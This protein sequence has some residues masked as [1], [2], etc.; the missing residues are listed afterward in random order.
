MSKNEELLK[1]MSEL[2]EGFIEEAEK[3]K[4]HTKGMLWKQLG[5]IAACALIAVSLAATP[6]ISKLSDNHEL[7]TELVDV[8]Y[9]RGQYVWDKTTGAF[10]WKMET[11]QDTEGKNEADE[12][13]AVIETGIVP[14]VG[15]PGG[16]SSALQTTTKPLEYEQAALMY[17]FIRGE[18]R[19]HALSFGYVMKS[20]IE[21]SLGAVT[22]TD[23]KG[24]K[25]TTH[26]KAAELFRI[27]GIDPA[28]AVAVK[29]EGFERYHVFINSSAQSETLTALK[30]AYSL[31]SKLYMGEV[32]V[33][34][35]M[36]TNTNTYKEFS[37]MTTL[38][39]MI[40]A[41]EGEAYS[42]Q[43][44]IKNRP[45]NVN[46]MGIGVTHISLNGMGQ[47]AIQIYEDGYLQTNIGGVLQ[48]FQIDT[49]A[50][51]EIIAYAREKNLDGVAFYDGSNTETE[52]G[53]MEVVTS[54]ALPVYYRLAGEYPL[55]LG[56][57]ASYQ[58][59]YG[60]VFEQHIE[61]CLGEVTMS[62]SK[63]SDTKQ[64]EIFRIHGIDPN[65]A[66]ALKFKDKTGNRDGEYLDQYE[67]YVNTEAEYAS[68]DALKEAYSLEEWLYLGNIHS[69]VN[70]TCI[71]RENVIAL[72]KMILSLNGA[73]CEE[74]EFEEGCMKQEWIKIRSYH[75]SFIGMTGNFVEIYT[76]GYLCVRIGKQD[77]FFKIDKDE[78][79]AIVASAEKHIADAG[80]DGIEFSSALKQGTDD[81]PETTSC[82]TMTTETVSEIFSEGMTIPAYDPRG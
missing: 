66:I 3:T 29:Y 25:E 17:P 35:D 80:N 61:D 69:I 16:T 27:K 54:N 13:N 7:G 4:W 42:M 60:G 76:G 30:Q 5:G 62:D 81:L 9:V 45:S 73:A 37:E 77:Y 22:M 24:D 39:E 47:M 68:F 1:K 44:F 33:T 52:T 48:L 31:D 2:D 67:L 50:A 63:G 64:A 8:L 26:S 82:E 28:Y 74:A 36:A 19:T 38:K 65:A 53:D 43:D 11:F 75:G 32:L 41:L 40:L 6:F 18:Y 20:N 78:A 55:I 59:T 58:L 51:K 14:V 15:E 79:T 12:T 23:E 49:M 10:V 21:E 56:E 46:Q 34:H 70:N 72:K 57:Y 71:E